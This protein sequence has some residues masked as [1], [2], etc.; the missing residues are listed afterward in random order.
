MFPLLIILFDHLAITLSADTVVSPQVSLDWASQT[1]VIPP[2]AF[3]KDI[4]QFVAG[5]FAWKKNKTP[6][7]NL[8]NIRKPFLMVRVALATNWKD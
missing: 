3:H 6:M 1:F 8:N 7:G 5:Y 4:G 2:G